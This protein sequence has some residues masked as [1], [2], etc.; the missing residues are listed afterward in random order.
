MHQ[1][2]LTTQLNVDNLFHEEYF[3]QMGFDDQLSFGRRRS[4]NASFSYR[5]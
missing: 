5:F 2:G 4:Y 3:G 1:R